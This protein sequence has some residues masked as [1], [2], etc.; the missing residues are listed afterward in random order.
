M[1]AGAPEGYAV[2]AQHVA[3]DVYQNKCTRHISGIAIIK[4]YVQTKTKLKR[5]QQYSQNPQR[6]PMSEGYEL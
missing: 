4:R 3:S 5:R 1:K 2:P 6:S